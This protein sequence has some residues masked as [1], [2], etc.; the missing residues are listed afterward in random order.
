MIRVP[1]RR[2]PLLNKPTVTAPVS[3]PTS[4]NA[5]IDWTT[6]FEWDAVLRRHTTKPTCKMRPGA[7][8]GAGIGAG[9][10]YASAVPKQLTGA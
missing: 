3:F 6:N 7:A 1:T 4:G 9:F 8:G 5:S 10:A 2:R